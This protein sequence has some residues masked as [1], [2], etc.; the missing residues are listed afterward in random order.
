MKKLTQIIGLCIGLSTLATGCKE[1]PKDQPKT[2]Q[3]QPNFNVKAMVCNGYPTTVIT[4]D[5]KLKYRIKNNGVQEVEP[6]CISFKTQDI[7]NNNIK[8]KDCKPVS[9]FAKL[10]WRD[11]GIDDDL[12]VTGDIK[13]EDVTLKLKGNKVFVTVNNYTALC[14]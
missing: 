13:P 10:D 9:N 4:Q 11:G 7:F 8:A 5:N 6:M 14:R 3:V 12:E 2:V 1:E